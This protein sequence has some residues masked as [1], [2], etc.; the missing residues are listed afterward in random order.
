[1]FVASDKGNNE[2]KMKRPGDATS[3]LSD[4]TKTTA[5]SSNDQSRLL[6]EQEGSQLGS[7]SGALK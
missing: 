3:A 2:T 4:V 7:E 1:M 6:C 5:E